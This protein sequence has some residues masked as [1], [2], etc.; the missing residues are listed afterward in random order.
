MPGTRS[1]DNK[2]AAAS[3]PGHKEPSI[4]LQ[5]PIGSPLLTKRPQF[6]PCHTLWRYDH[7]SVCS[8][9]PV[10]LPFSEPEHDRRSWVLFYLLRFQQIDHG[11]RMGHR[12]GF[13][14]TGDGGSA[15]PMAKDE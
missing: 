6:P 15:V 9:L 14:S 1:V 10:S 8:R 11:P 12:K 2:K 3:Q 7:D 13:G 5:I 4:K